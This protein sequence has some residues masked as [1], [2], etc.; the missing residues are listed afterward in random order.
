MSSRASILISGASQRLPVFEVQ[1]VS[2]RST[3]ASASTNALIDGLASFAY[4]T[5][6]ADRFNWVQLTLS[7]S[8]NVAAIEVW[9][10]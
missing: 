8:Y 7:A 6:I 10:R 4:V 5:A 2:A 3:H 1:S 9:L